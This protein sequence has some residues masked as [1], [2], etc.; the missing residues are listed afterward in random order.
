MRLHHLLP[1]LSL[2][3]AFAPTPRP[4]GE[5]R[6]ERGDVPGWVL[7][8]LMTAALVL[9]LWGLA[10]AGFEELWNRAMQMVGG[11]G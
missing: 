1:V 10:S 2:L 8:T 11:I 3:R 7:I 4:A 9:V 6:S 5:L